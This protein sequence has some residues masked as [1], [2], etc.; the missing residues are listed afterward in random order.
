[1]CRP[2]INCYSFAPVTNLVNEEITWHQIPLSGSAICL[3]E[4]LSVSLPA[5]RWLKCDSAMLYF[6]CIPKLEAESS[7]SINNKLCGRSRHNMPLPPAS[8]PLTFWPW[9]W[10]PSNV[11]RGLPL[12]QSLFSTRPN[13][14]DRQTSD[15]QTS[16]AHR[17]LMPVPLGRG[18]NN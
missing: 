11:W 14:C 10:C 3:L 16:D 6:S 4:F 13:V 15:R 7:L 8:W 2:I 1:M 18:H 12:C 17:C 9:K 5:I